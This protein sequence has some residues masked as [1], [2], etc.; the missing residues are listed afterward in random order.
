VRDDVYA[1][2]GHYL[3]VHN[4]VPSFERLA[5]GAVGR[6]GARKLPARPRPDD[7]EA[8]VAPVY[9]LAAALA[10][11]GAARRN[12]ST[13]VWQALTRPGL[14]GRLAG[15]VA[16]PAAVAA[17]NAAGLGPL[18]PDL[19]GEELRDSALRAMGAVVEKLD[20]RAEHV[21]FGHTHR[22][23]P[24]PGDSGWGP[25]VNSGSWVLEPAFL[26]DR[27][28]ES[29]YFPGHCVVVPDSGPPE[30]RRLLDELPTGT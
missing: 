11:A 17:L 9:A 23:G 24:H 25:L 21:V 26:G 2:H 27:P 12:H 28:R 22:S 5:I 30:L 19:S 1:T 14:R 8:A 13:R 6:I 4:T 15:A 7:Y 20:I 16:L 29:P 10:Q 3:D 18:R